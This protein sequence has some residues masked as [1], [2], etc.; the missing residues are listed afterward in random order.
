M[1]QSSGC[2]VETRDDTAHFQA[3]T[4]G[5][6]VPHPMCRRTEG[7]STTARRCGGVFRDSGAGYKTANLLA[8][9]LVNF[10]SRHFRDSSQIPRDFQVSQTI[11][12]TF[13]GR[14]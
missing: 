7:T 10:M 6:S 8:Q 1:E 12:V 13:I 5:L 9:H 4:Q 14:L 2:S 11:M 3:T